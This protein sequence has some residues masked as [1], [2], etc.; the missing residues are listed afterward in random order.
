M[1]EAKGEKPFCIYRAM[2]VLIRTKFIPLTQSSCIVKDNA[3]TCQ[4]VNEKN[5]GSFRNVNRLCS[6]RK[7]DWK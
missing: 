6:E 5:R 3:F 4:Y 2:C 7:R 1:R